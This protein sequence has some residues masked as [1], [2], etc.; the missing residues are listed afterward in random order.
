MALHLPVCHLL[1]NACIGMQGMECTAHLYKC[2]RHCRHRC[3]PRC[4][5]CPRWELGAL[6]CWVACTGLG[7]APDCQDKAVNCGGLALA[8]PPFYN[9]TR[10]K[11]MQGKQNIGHPN[12]HSKLRSL[13]WS[14]L[15]VSHLSDLSHWS[16]ADCIRQQANAQQLSRINASQ[17]HARPSLYV[18]LHRS[19]TDLD[20]KRLKKCTLATNQNHTAVIWIVKLRTNTASFVST[21]FDL[22][23]LARGD[24]WALF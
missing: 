19:P 5:R 7:T 22:F 15:A 23:R 13:I 3:H 4:P 2:C 11:D 10:D 21:C 16:H 12:I 24:S 8:F 14:A 6:A 9:V 17:I 18:S 1:S 20:Q